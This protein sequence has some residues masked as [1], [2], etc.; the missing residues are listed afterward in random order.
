MPACPP[1]LVSREPLPQFPAWRPNDSSGIV[2]GA[3]AFAVGH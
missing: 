3:S 1:G 2:R